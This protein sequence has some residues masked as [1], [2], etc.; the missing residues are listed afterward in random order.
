LAVATVASLCA[1]LAW[2]AL[3]RRHGHKMLRTICRISLSPDS[4]IRQTEQLYNRWGP[5]SLLLAKM[6]PGFASVATTLAGTVRTP[7]A[8]FIVFDALGAMLW[9]G[10]A[11]ALG[12]LFQDAVGD[13]LEVLSALGR[14]GLLLVT[15]ALAVFVLNK[16]W[17]RRMLIAQL[18]MER[19][20]VDDLQTMLENGDVPVIL[21]VRPPAAHEE[22]RIPGARPVNMNEPASAVGGLPSDIE[23]VVYCSCPNEISAAKVAKALLQGGFKN[24]R[25]LAGGIDAWQEAGLDVERGPAA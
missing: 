20:S 25:P 16:W 8:A 13:V 15:V 9:A 1:D 19:I 6:I 24:V 18:Q 11:I 3:G 22:A 2:F 12:H 17:R 21:D 5:K 10:I 4:C 14:I 7:L 23:V